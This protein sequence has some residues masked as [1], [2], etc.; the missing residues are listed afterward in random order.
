M[1]LFQRIVLLLKVLVLL[2]V[3]ASAAWASNPLS[4]AGAGYSVTGVP[5]PTIHAIYKSDSEPGDQGQGGSSG[6]DDQTDGDGGAD[7]GGD[8]GDEGDAGD[9]G[10]SQT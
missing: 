10:D 7:G 9:E 3:S 8:N 4:S 2:T 1:K 5:G 6:D